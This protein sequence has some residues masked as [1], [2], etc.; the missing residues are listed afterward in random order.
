VKQ[1]ADGIR[2]AFPPQPLEQIRLGTSR[3]LEAA[4]SWHVLTDPSHHALH[5]P[6]V[7]ACRQLPA[8]LRQQ[9]REHSWAVRTYLPAF[10]EAGI[11]HPDSTIEEEIALI[12]AVPARQ[13]APE[14]VLTLVDWPRGDDLGDPGVPDLIIGVA[15]DQH[16]A[17]RL[18][19]IFADPG[20]V[21][22]QLLT[23]IEDYWQACFA[24]EFERLEPGLHQAMEDAARQLAA[25]GPLGLLRE[26]IPEVILDPASSTV[27]IPRSH[28]H[29]VAV[30]EHGGITLVPSVYAW[31]HVRVTCDHPPWPLTLIY[32]A[33]PLTRPLAATLTPGQLA[34]QLTAVA[35]APRL[36]LLRLT[37]IEPRSTQELARLTQLSQAAVSKHLQT[38]L[39]A[40]LLTRTRQSYY[41]LYA[42]DRDRISAFV[43]ALGRELNASHAGTAVRPA[44]GRDP[45]RRGS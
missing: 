18:R 17:A 32:P 26:L 10:L 11:A 37:S 39:A 8:G 40:G 2:L 21:R 41:V 44:G 28:H 29:Q 9:L 5:L 22:D 14:L 24:A 7:R 20:R 30:G 35:A 19:R 34:R 16:D 6:W 31:P 4:Q 12:R 23:V 25:A 13:L 43:E 38:L 33:D 15:R 45:H 36:E 1:L 27:L 42:A 3:V